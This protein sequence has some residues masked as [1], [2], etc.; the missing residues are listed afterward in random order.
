MPLSATEVVPFSSR[1]AEGTGLE[2]HTV[3]GW[4][5]AEGGPATN[6]L[7]IGP[8]RVY[9]SMEAAAIATVKLLTQSG[10]YTDLVKTARGTKNISDEANA[11]ARSPWKG[12]D[13]LPRSKYADNIRG[14]AARAIYMDV[15]PTTVD[16]GDGTYV[17]PTDRPFTDDSLVGKANSIAGGVGGFFD[18]TSK[19]DNW[20]RVAMIVGGGVIIIVGAKTVIS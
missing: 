11:I 6:P 19:R 15:K 8:G 16:N 18:W 20:V 1:V 17:T 7:N 12:D 9:E 5:A 4:Y 14:G 10:L 2:F 13:G 3:E